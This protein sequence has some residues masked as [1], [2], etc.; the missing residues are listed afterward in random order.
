MIKDKEIK[1]S[2]NVIIIIADNVIAK[3]IIKRVS[4][5]LSSHL[6]KTTYKLIENSPLFCHIYIIFVYITAFFLAIWINRI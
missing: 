2:F 3:D 1:L 5:A 6:S 4:S